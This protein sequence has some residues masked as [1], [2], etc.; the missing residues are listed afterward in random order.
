MSGSGADRRMAI[1]IFLVILAGS[2]PRASDPRTARMIG[3]VLVVLFA[4]R[5]AVFEARW[6]E[7]DGGY[8][9]DIAALDTMPDGTRLAVV[10]P[11]VPS[12]SAR[13]RNCTC[14][15]WQSRAA[16]RS[17]LRCSRMLRNSRSS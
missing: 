17:C 5:L 1:V 8:R 10:W 12:R 6:L 7:A 11:A 16:M 2:L 4:M 15:R 14:R 13:I 3:A 9:A